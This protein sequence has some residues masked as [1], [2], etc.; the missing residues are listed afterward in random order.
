MPEDISLLYSIYLKHRLICID[1]RNVQKN[2]IF[3]ALKG[4]NFNGNKFAKEAID[5][6][7]PYVIID[8]IN[9]KKDERFIIVNNVLETLQ[10]LAL[11][12]REQLNI[13]VIGIT[14]TNGKTTT[15]DL[16]KCVLNKKYKTFATRGNLN[17]HIGVPL[18]ILSI[19]NDSE[20]AIIEMGANHI[21]EIEQLCKIAQPDHGIITNIGKAHLEGFGGEEGVINAKKELYSYLKQNK[22]VFFVNS[23]NELLIK[24]LKE[25]NITKAW[26]YTCFTYGASKAANYRGKIINI[27]PVQLKWETFI[28]TQ[29]F[30]KH[31]FENIMAAICIGSYFKVKGSEIKQA[32]ENY[33]PADNRGQIIKTKKN[34]VLLDAYNAN[35]TN[36][37]A[38]ISNF[39]QIQAEN[40]IIILGDMLELGSFGLKE[41]KAIIKLIKDQDFIQII[42]VGDNFSKAKRSVKCTHFADVNAAYNWLKHRN[43]INSFILIKGSRGIQLEKLMEVL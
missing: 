15:K 32:I 18:S 41:H 38:A 17:N 34:K 33:K 3:F 9:Y 2:S 26:Q 30:G 31:N 22:G 23:D 43:I 12:H 21:G 40:K 5:K 37:A 28:N 24:M 35:P 14:G 10:K 11:H 19:S 29:L 20:I 36:M 25:Q 4:E 7:C 39:S 27:N 42:L 6:G 13:P 1:S 16:I 8:E